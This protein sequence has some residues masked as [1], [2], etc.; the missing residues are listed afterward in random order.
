MIMKCKS[1]TAKLGDL[2][3][4]LLKKLEEKQLNLMQ[5]CLVISLNA[6]MKGWPHC[7]PV[8]IVDETFL[9]ST[10]G[11][12]LLVA[13]TQDAKGKI[14]PLAFCVVDSENDDSWEWFFDKFRK[15]YG[16]REDM[17]IVFD[18]HESIIK[19]INTVY[20]EV[21]H[22]ACTFHLLKNMKSNFK[23]SSKKFKDTFFAAANAYTV[24]KF[25]YKMRELDKIDKRLGPY[26]Q[27]IGYHKWARIQSPTNRYSNMTSNTAESL[28]SAIVAVRELPICTMLECLRALVQR[29]SWTNRNIANAT[30][31]KLTDKH[32][33]ILN[34][35]YIYS[36]KL[37]VHPTNHIVYEVH[38][39]G[40]KSIV[41]LN[42]R[43]CTCNRFQMD[44]LPCAHAI[45][46]FKEMNQDPYQYCS[47][48]YTKE[49]M[50][51]TYKESI[52]PLG[53]EDT[54]LIPEHIKAVK[55]HPPEG[56]IRVGRPNKRRC[57]AA[58]EKN[59][60]RKKQNKCGNCSQSGHNRKTCRDP[61]KKD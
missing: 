11:G 26:L 35:N 54:W 3:K 18:R 12:T 30:S 14:F 41:D 42:S 8:V 52:Y 53:N 32:E 10:Y 34:D 57:Q 49:A 17:S 60:K 29:W 27:Q 36:L 2:E 20:P 28:N 4:K 50:V 46:V 31:T 22:G 38:D 1:N 37:T 21:P 23:K 7:I 5:N 51:A 44:Q 47:P 19:A 25:E 59:K 55:I 45:A 56:K 58:W 39:D 24:K 61:R 40:K 43:T 33:V 6:S 13:A 15:A 9:K 48:Y 16:V